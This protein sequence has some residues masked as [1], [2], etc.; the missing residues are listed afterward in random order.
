MVDL[1]YIEICVCRGN[2][3]QANSLQQSYHPT[4]L[5]KQEKISFK[6]KNVIVKII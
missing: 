6:I 3:F 5:F 1:A 2:P 4:Q